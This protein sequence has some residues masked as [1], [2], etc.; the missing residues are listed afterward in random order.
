LSNV[1]AEDVAAAIVHLSHRE[2][3]V[4]K[5]FNI[6]DDSHPTVEE[7]L[8][9]AARTFGKKTP[10]VHL[11][12]GLVK[13]FARFDGFVSKIKRRIPDL[14]YDAVRYLVDDYIVDNTRLKNTGYRL[15]YPDFAQSM[16]QIRDW[17]QDLP[18]KEAKIERVK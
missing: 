17:Y 1:R 7:A 5:A 8:T 11:P 15:I 13:V 3:A 10:R 2:D 12:I 18:H 14:E 16:N 4:G 6:S 9:I